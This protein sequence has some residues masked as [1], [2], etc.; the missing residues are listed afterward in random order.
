[1]LPHGEQELF[2]RKTEK[3]KQTEKVFYVKQE[4]G[5]FY[6]TINQFKSDG[7]QAGKRLHNGF[8][9]QQVREVADA[10]GFDF[11]GHHDHTVNGGCDVHTLAYQ[12]F[13]APMVA[14]IQ[15]LTK[16]N[17]MMMSILEKNDLI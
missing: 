6:V 5:E 15:E 10:M 3:V 13:I 1:M 2:L 4:R 11:A 12:E 7:S 8:I 17:K 14:S 16:Q 9:A